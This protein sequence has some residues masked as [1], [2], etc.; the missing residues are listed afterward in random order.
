[1]AAWV[2]ANPP[3][4]APDEPA[5]HIKAV[6]SALGE[7]TGTPVG[8]LEGHPPIRRPFLAHVL[9]TFRLPPR[10][11]S[12]PR[13]A[14]N[15]FTRASAACLES[16]LP[17]AATP[18]MGERVAQQSI[19]GPYPPVLY[20]VIGAA[21]LAAGGSRPALYAERLIVAV[22]CLGFLAI[23]LHYSKA[24]W[25]RLAVLL[26]G[27]PTVLF[28]SSAVT[29][30]GIEITA[31]LA[32]TATVLALVDRPPGE[33][34]WI[35]WALTGSVLVLAR[36]LGPLWLAGSIALL[37]ATAG[38]TGLRQRVQAQQT[39]ARP[40][41]AALSC[42]AI[43]AVGWSLFV[44]PHDH[45]TPEK[46]LHFL[47]PALRLFP[48]LVT[49]GVGVF[50]WLDVGVPVVAVLLIGAG[51]ATLIG[52]GMVVGTGR[53]RVIL[54]TSVCSLMALVL[55][56]QTFTQLPFGFR[57]QARYVMP[58]LVGV[59]LFAGRTIDDGLARA[60]PRLAT[61]CLWFPAVGAAAVAAV[62]WIGWYVNARR[63]AVGLDGPW[64]FFSQ[65][66]W[67]PPGGWIP[68]LAAATLGAILLARGAH[69]CDDRFSAD[70]EGS[71]RS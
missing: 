11:A 64:L 16:P 42:A 56:L 1:M 62:Q 17:P 19:L 57:A 27:T 2:G 29:T 47:G 5:H 40:A 32:H 23:A 4:S 44:M 3:G 58:M 12:D 41:I 9:Q 38:W 26:A 10:L 25:T 65:P 15:A 18:A 33:R 7:F 69:Y 70:V 31:G 49:Q 14:C 71:A 39:M 30:S 43:I 59:L 54:A 53:D 22:L 48:D 68:W 46:A 36:P 61:R 28:M 37:L 13:W 52:T 66:L 35:G 50:G 20:P 67:A 8:T 6:A 55:L 45:V 60:A 34:P 21:A 24:T 51:W 63:S